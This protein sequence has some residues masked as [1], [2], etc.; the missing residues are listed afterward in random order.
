MTPA[1]ADDHHPRLR[2]GKLP[3]P[4]TIVNGY[5]EAGERM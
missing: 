3:S 5:G 1:F 2:R 4:M